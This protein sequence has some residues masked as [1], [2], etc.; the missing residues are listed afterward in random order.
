MQSIPAPHVIVPLA[1]IFSFIGGLS[2]LLGYRSKHGAWLIILFLAATNFSMH[3]F[4]MFPD[5]IT[6]EFQQLMF[7]KN[8][9]L[10]GA[11]FIISFFGSGP[12]SLDKQ[13]PAKTKG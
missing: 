11:A 8:I 9:S 7:M 5:P 6:K 3:R 4:W 2:I 1:G 10:L 12:Y 13:I